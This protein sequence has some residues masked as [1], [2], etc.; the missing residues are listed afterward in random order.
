[1]GAGD[2][3]EQGSDAEYDEAQLEASKKPPKNKASGQSSA[4]QQSSASTGTTAWSNPPDTLEPFSEEKNARRRG[5]G[6]KKGMQGSG[7]DENDVWQG[8]GS[9]DG[10][11]TSGGFGGDP[12]LDS[13]DAQGGFVANVRRESERRMSQHEMQE[14]ADDALREASWDEELAHPGGAQPVPGSRGRSALLESGM[15]GSSAP[16]DM[17]GSFRTPISLQGQA[18][19][20]S[21]GDLGAPNVLSGTDVVNLSRGS[22]IPALDSD[23][24]LFSAEQVGG[25][26]ADE[27]RII[28]AKPPVVV[29]VRAWRKDGAHLY[30]A[31]PTWVWD[32]DTGKWIAELRHRIQPD[33][34]NYD[35]AHAARG[36][37]RAPRRMMESP[38]AYVGRGAEAGTMNRVSMHRLTKREPYLGPNT[39]WMGMG[40]AQGA[41]GDYDED[42][43]IQWR[44][45][46][47]FRELRGGG[48]AGY[49]A[50]IG[51]PGINLAA[52]G[53][54]SGGGGSRRSI[55]KQYMDTSGSGHKQ[56]R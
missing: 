2:S 22:E 33:S 14:Q 41:F 44:G 40:P 49:P 4:G 29:M 10:F 23:A 45:D 39:H 9:Q 1:M 15:F 27:R 3:K 36:G 42:D 50:A 37:L 51:V 54:M 46:L 7:S 18:Q 24:G 30:E 16:P 53:K 19:G 11:I 35:D 55:E 21:A 8:S 20:S 5:R 26:D 25:D 47:D 31:Q 6:R 38:Y 48:R 43:D 32:D 34:G 56:G 17:I 13:R 52:L 12:A 28:H